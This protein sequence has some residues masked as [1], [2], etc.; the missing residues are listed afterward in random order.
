MGGEPNPL[1]SVS[2]RDVDRRP[3][4]Q[5]LTVDETAAVLRTS[6]KAVYVMAQRGQLPGRIR[7]GRRML[8]DAAILV[9]WLRQKSAPLPK[10]RR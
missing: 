1:A 7:L 10:E 3:L 4:P 5:L 6:P 9:E 8:F 2:R